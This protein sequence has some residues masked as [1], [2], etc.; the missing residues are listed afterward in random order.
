MLRIILAGTL[1]L[2]PVPMAAQI[3]AQIPANLTLDWD[4]GI[5]PIGQDNYYKAIECGKQGGDNPVC[6]FYDAGLCKN[7]D[8]VLALHTPYKYVAYEVW[9]AVRQKQPAPQPNYATAGR[10]R[11]TLGISP[12]AG[13]QNRITAVSIKRGGR[14]FQPT[15][16]SIDG[17]RGSFTFDFAPWA[18]TSDI[19]IEMAGTTG[20]KTCLVPRTLLAR[21]R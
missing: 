10:T 21:F 1:A 5:Q 20:T 16:R 3:R 4:K 17:G 12:A 8:F 14:T 9:N 15:S 7:D 11:V 13:S 6:L 2:A 19:T 18:P